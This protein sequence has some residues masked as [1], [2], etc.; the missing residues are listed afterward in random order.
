MPDRDPEVRQILEEHAESFEEVKQKLAAKQSPHH[1][2]SQAQL[3][4]AVSEY[5]AAYQRF[6]ETVYACVPSHG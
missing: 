5:T 2:R 3:N 4:A 6:S 1:P